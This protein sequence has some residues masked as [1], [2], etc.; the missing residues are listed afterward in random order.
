[1]L[2]IR[3]TEWGERILCVCVCVRAQYACVLLS[4]TDPRRVVGFFQSVQFFPRCQ[5]GVATSKLLTFGAKIQK[6][7]LHIFANV[8]IRPEV[9]KIIEIKNWQSYEFMTNKNDSYFQIKYTILL[10]N[11]L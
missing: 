4:L 8:I 3:E 9:A 7:E 10:K 6:S 5:D 2:G 11:F 1:M